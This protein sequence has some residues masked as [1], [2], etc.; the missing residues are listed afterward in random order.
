LPCATIVSK[1]LDHQ[2][3]QPVWLCVV[4]YPA[5]LEPGDQRMPKR[6]LNSQ[7]CGGVSAEQRLDLDHLPVPVHGLLAEGG[8]QEHVPVERLDG[9]DRKQRMRRGV[10]PTVRNVGQLLSG[11]TIERSGE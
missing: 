8:R 6:F 11:G 9:R 2:L 7:R 5:V 10:P 4:G 1:D 3:V